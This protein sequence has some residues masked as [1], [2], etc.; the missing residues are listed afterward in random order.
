MRLVEPPTHAVLWRSHYPCRQALTTSAARQPAALPL[1]WQLATVGLIV[2]ETVNCG[3]ATSASQNAPGPEGQRETLILQIR[4]TRRYE[5]PCYA[6]FFP[7]MTDLRYALSVRSEKQ[8]VRSARWRSTDMCPCDV[9][10]MTVRLVEIPPTLANG[11]EPVESESG[12]N[13]SPFT[14]SP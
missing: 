12:A 9:A 13:V 11:D 6:S 4:S 3:G 8:E 2:P 1:N 10:C 14:C 7:S 5:K